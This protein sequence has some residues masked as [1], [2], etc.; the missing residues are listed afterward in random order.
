MPD[1]VKCHAVNKAAESK[2][3]QILARLITEAELSEPDLEAVYVALKFP[4]YH[5]KKQVRK[6]SEQL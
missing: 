2:G 3:W 4:V 1:F 5:E 6:D